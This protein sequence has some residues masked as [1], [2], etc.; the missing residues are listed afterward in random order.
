MREYYN[1]FL[2]PGLIENAV[3]RETSRLDSA[4][5]NPAG[6]GLRTLKIHTEISKPKKQNGYTKPVIELSEQTRT[7]QKTAAGVLSK[8][9]LNS[10]PGFALEKQQRTVL[11]RS[12]LPRTDTAADREILSLALALALALTLTLH[13]RMTV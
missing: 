1:T 10:D 8:K 4:C 13:L 7:N 9:T 12:V 11:F 2:P 3:S 5:K 6:A